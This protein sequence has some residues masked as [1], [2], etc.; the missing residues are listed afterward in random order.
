MQCL[1]H[2]RGELEF[3]PSSDRQPA[4]FPQNGC[5]VFTTTSPLSALSA[6]LLHSIGLQSLIKVVGDAVAVVQ[7]TGDEFLIFAA[8]S[9]NDR[10]A[11]LMSRR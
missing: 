7:A 8:S 6:W 5:D 2:E 9:D 10:S 1:E 4:H 11:G 3:D